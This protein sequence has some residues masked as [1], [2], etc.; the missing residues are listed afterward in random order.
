[1]VRILREPGYGETV[2]ERRLVGGGGPAATAGPATRHAWSATGVRSGGA[3]GH[4]LRAQDGHP[5]GVAAPGDGLWQWRHLLAAAARL[6]A[7]RRVAPAPPGVA[8]PSGRGG[9]HR[10]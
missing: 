2:G 4:H 9:P 7:G 3:G 8:G 6:A 10:L 1:M 5:L